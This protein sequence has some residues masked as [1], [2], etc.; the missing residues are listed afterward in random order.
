MKQHDPLGSGTY[1]PNKMPFKVK[2]KCR[3]DREASMTGAASTATPG[4]RFGRGGFHLF[5]GL[6]GPFFSITLR[7]P[8]A[9]R[10][11]KGRHGNLAAHAFTPPAGRAVVPIRCRDPLEFLFGLST[12]FTAVFV[13][14]HGFLVVETAFGRNLKVYR[15]P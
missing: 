6:G 5:S 13:K 10:Q 7:V 2:A 8:A 15:G 12:G 4:G 3:W 14:R 1:D 11:G 9:S